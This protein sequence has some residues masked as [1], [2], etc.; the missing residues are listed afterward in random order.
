MTDAAYLKSTVGDALS[1]GMKLTIP[2]LLIF[3]EGEAMDFT[4]HTAFTYACIR[5]A[6]CSNSTLTLVLAQN[7]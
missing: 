5:D 6:R 3:R 2:K 4:G 7:N 1:K